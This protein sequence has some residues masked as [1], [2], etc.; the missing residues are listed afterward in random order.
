MKGLLMVGALAGLALGGCQKAGEGSAG[1][2]FGGSARGRYTGVG[3]YTPGPIW[4][5]LK[6]AIAPTDP[7]A[8]TLADDEQVIVVLDTATGE[9][10]QCGNLS[11][12]CIGMNPWSRP[13][14][15]P[16]G[17]PAQLLKHA[18]DLAKEADAQIAV[19]VKPR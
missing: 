14:P 7:A 12:H 3:F 5:Q 18:E 2:L 16:Q 19:E 13:L 15:A 9:L 17:V 8:A 11:G 10:R 4:T 6:G 1:G